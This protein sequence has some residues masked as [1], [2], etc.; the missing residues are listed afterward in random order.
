[1]PLPRTTT[2]P[3]EQTAA[4]ASPFK[5]ELELPALS[6]NQAV[7]VVNMKEAGGSYVRYVGGDWLP[8]GGDTF[9]KAAR[10]VFRATDRTILSLIRNGY[11]QVAQ[12]LNGRPVRV[13][14]T[15]P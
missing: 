1:M 11:L 9:S 8:P 2:F 3:V 6:A 5:S 12:E 4:P 10:D 7:T 14:L 13:T 15:F